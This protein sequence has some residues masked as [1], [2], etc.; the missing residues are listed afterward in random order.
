MLIESCIKKTKNQQYFL[1]LEKKQAE[2]STI[3]RLVT[4]KKYLVKH[5]DINNEIFSSFKPLFERTDQI[6]KLNQNALPQSIT[7]PSVTNDQKV[8]CDNDSLLAMTG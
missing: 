4:D 7:S 2:K 6:H 8:V 5:N 1:N 3:R